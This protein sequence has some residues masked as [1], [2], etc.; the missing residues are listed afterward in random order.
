MQKIYYFYILPLCKNLF[1]TND[2]YNNPTLQA[3]GYSSFQVQVEDATH[4]SCM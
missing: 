4:V 3:E 1:E 2:G